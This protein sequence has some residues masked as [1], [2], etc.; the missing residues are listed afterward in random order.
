M[1]IA[2][3]ASS[4]NR[5][6]HTSEAKRNTPFSL[7]L[8]FCLAL[9]AS[10]TTARAQTTQQ[11]GQVVPESAAAAAPVGEVIDDDDVLSIDS[12]LVSI[13][14]TVNE[15]TGRAVPDLN[16]EDFE[17]R[18]DGQLKAIGELGRADTPV[19][20][21]VL[22]DNSSSLSKAREFEKQA[23]TRFFQR[24]VRPI[25]RAA[26]YSV[27][28]V[29]VLARPLTNGVPALVRTV[30]QFPDPEGATALFDA[31][32][33]AARY[34][35]PH[36]GRKVIVIVSD[37]NDTISELSF[38]QAVRSALSAGCQIYVV[39]TGDIENPNLTD[40]IAR[41]RLQVMAAQT[42]GA[43][44]VPRTVEDLDTAFEQVSKDVSQQYVVSYYP[45]DDPS[46]GRF[47]TIDLRVK[48]RP[49]LRVRAREGYYATNGQSRVRPRRARGAQ[50][51]DAVGAGVKGSAQ[52][53]RKQVASIDPL[54]AQ[55]SA[56]MSAGRN[57]SAAAGGVSF[58]TKAAD[59][60]R[61]SPRPGPQD[62]QAEPS[63]AAAATPTPA[64]SI[65]P[66][67]VRAA[68]ETA[69]A[70]KPESHAS[71]AGF[72]GTLSAAPVA[73]TVEMAKVEPAKVEPVKVES[74]PEPTPAAAK[75]EGPRAPVSGG[76]LN[77]KAKILPKPF[78]PTTARN[79]GAKGSV[80]VEV[81][82][83]EEGKVVSAQAVSGHLLLQNAAVLAAR[84]AR[85]AP[86]L[87][88]GQ[89]VRIKGRIVYN[90]L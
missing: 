88:S 70:V 10:A 49:T 89:P 64:R 12:N 36:E 62:E 87:L 25:D 2:R 72:K 4:P 48:T 82:I 28:T 46:D 16:L 61:P 31:I 35:R 67:L 85:F 8:L 66:Q 65:D 38:D 74:A 50:E 26:I 42:G 30:E 77:G 52:D 63:N 47:R 41:R 39:G 44:Y 29:P 19:V 51:T 69:L 6:A 55:P 68:T 81:E 80:S 90:F 7:T 37:G 15:S 5:F 32:A 43:L 9:A 78:Y 79:V 40:T 34:L 56:I 53:S 1:K 60:V 13:P 22:F 27:S 18:V 54:Y 73:P 86:T 76:V 45:T 58:R 71:T 17:L 57:E 59:G 83:D 11:Q 84:Q 21:A 33:E 3:P 14:A 75:N 24:I 20:L 23:A